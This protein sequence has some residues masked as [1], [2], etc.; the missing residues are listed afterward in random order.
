[1]AVHYDPEAGY[2]VTAFR[3]T[4]TVVPLVL[5]HLEFWAFFLLHLAVC[6]AF[7]N[8]YLEGANHPRSFLCLGWNEMK[9]IAAATTF[10]EVFYTNQ[11]FSR[12]N[13]LYDLSRKML[14]NLYDFAF[15]V[16]LHLR[17]SSQSHVRLAARWFTASVI[18]FFYET[19]SDVSDRE[20]AELLR[21][22]LL[23]PDEKAFLEN[24]HKHQR[25]LVLLQWSAE[26]CRD[27]CNSAKVPANALKS[28]VDKLLKSRIL[29]QAV[30]DTIELPMPFQYF[31]L[32]NMM[33]VVNLLLWA[34]GMGTSA[35]LFAP[36]TFF[37]AALIFMGMLELAAALS[38]P[39]GDDEVDFPVVDWLNEFLENTIV[40]LEFD[41]P[42]TMEDRLQKETP[43]RPGKR[44]L[45]LFVQENLSLGMD[46]SHAPAPKRLPD[47]L[48]GRHHHHHREDSGD[49][50]DGDD[51]D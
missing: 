29:E 33:V 48:P 9:V 16:R 38:D 24:F 13:S 45:N 12:Y 23:K 18:L 41:C 4:N 21:Q 10:F 36:V 15:E 6:W 39:F 37:F 51:S 49:D 31:H 26:V 28:L 11:C 46:H 7:R 14:G 5:S 30:V 47:R 22:G 19:N 3:L 32:L 2:L 20:W 44:H 35:S 25:S 8:G 17:K 42:I 43:M 27:G 1:M 40:L 34:Y 50:E